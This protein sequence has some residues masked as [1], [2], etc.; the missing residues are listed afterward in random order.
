VQ[1][2]HIGQKRFSVAKLLRHRPLQ[3]LGTVVVSRARPITLLVE[4][5]FIFLARPSL[6]V[7]A[8]ML[9]MSVIES[10]GPRASDCSDAS[11]F[12]ASGESADGSSTGRADAH[13]L[14]SVDATLM[15][16][17]LAMRTVTG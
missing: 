14:R 3:T 7:V 17:I 1:Q 4:M 5:Q 16:N 6:L 11:A 2:N 13:P 15:L 12:A 10:A 8:V 9:L